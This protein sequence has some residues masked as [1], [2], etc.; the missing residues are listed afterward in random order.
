MH[1]LPCLILINSMLK[2]ASRD[3]K[4]IVSAEPSGKELLIRV[5]RQ[6]FLKDIGSSNL[7]EE[8]WCWPVAQRLATDCGGHLQPTVIKH[9]THLTSLFLPI[10]QISS[11]SESKHVGQDGKA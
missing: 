1:S 11:N 4:I 5:E 8:N 7:E 2:R 3:G 6:G 10:K 9:D